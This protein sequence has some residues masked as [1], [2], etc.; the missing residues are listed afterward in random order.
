MSATH[1]TNKLRSAEDTVDP[2]TRFKLGKQTLIDTSHS[3]S[4][5][6]FEWDARKQVVGS[7]GGFLGL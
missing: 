1:G 7:T 6:M 3:P 4:L 5:D 2:S